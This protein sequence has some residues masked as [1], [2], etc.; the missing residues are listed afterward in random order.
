MK[1]NPR[2]INIP[3]RDSEE[4]KLEFIVR[5]AFF[6]GLTINGGTYGVSDNNGTFTVS[7][8][9]GTATRIEVAI[10]LQ[11]LVGLMVK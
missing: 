11:R 3:S 1:D 10:I 8:G 5:Y 6:L 4:W 7:G 2:L 9:R